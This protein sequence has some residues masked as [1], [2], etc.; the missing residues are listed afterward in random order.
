MFRLGSRVE[1]FHPVPGARVE[2]LA[3]KNLMKGF[4]S[5]ATSYACL[6]FILYNVLIVILVSTLTCCV[7]S[8]SSRK[9][10]SCL[11]L[12]PEDLAP[13]AELEA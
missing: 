10:Q 13:E 1:S 2:F 12:K 8:L 9:L 4:Q 5:N 11:V 6:Y 7:A 3:T